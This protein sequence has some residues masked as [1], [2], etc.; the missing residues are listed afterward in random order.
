MNYISFYIAYKF[1]RSKKS[2]RFTSIISKSS[3]IGISL[4][5]AAIIV[6][7]SIM[8]GFHNEMRNKI[9]SMVSHVIITEENYTLKNWDKL[10][11]KIDKNN[12]VYS[13]APY[14]EGQA[15]ISFGNN[16]HGIQVKGIIPEYEKNVTS[17]ENN[18]IDGQLNTIGNK[19]YQ[20][21]IGIDLAK[22]MSLKIGDKITLVI[23]R[24]NSTMIGIVPRIKRFEVS[25]IFNFG[26]QQYDKNLVFID[27]KE[28]QLLYGKGADVTGLRLKLNDL[29]LA[30][31]MSEIIKFNYTPNYIVI[32]WTMMNKNFFNALQMEKTML[33]LLMLLIVLVATFNIISSLFMVVSEKKSDIAILKTIGMNSRNIMKIFILQGTFLGAAGIILGLILGLLISFNLDYIVKLIEYFLGRSILDSDIY[34]ISSV[35]AKV[36]LLDLFYV[37]I[38][39][40]LLS[41]LATL[42]P[43]INAAKTKPAEA[44]RGN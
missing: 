5:I 27:I 39:S 32:D 28:A 26:M 10:K 3:I 24:A 23:P 40:F 2:S 38:A 13:S 19:P 36:E 9:L 33:L 44:L 15:M 6:V 42:Y 4:G 7:M 35:P 18:I 30:P 16:V 17:L 11:N 14:V 43:S 29:F 12:L 25:S 37:S 22:K 41:V 34:M 21:S 8:N 31:S 20:I 1:L